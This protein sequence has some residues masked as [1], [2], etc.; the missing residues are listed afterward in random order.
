ME[1]EENINKKKRRNKELEKKKKKKKEEIK[2]NILDSKYDLMWKNRIKN[3]KFQNIDAVVSVWDWAWEYSTSNKLWG[4]AA[5]HYVTMS[6]KEMKNIE[7]DNILN[8]HAIVYMWT[9]PP[10]LQKA[11]IL[12]NS[13][14]LKF[15]NIN[16][17]WGKLDEDGKLSR[18]CLGFYVRQQEEYLMMFTKGNPD[19]SQ[20]DINKVN[21]IRTVRGEHSEKPKEII[22][23]ID[24]T[25][26]NVTKL[27][28]FSRSTINI[29]FQNFGNQ[30][31]LLVNTQFDKKSLLKV[32]NEQYELVLKKN[33]EENPNFFSKDKEI[34]IFSNSRQVS[35]FDCFEKIKVKKKKEKKEK[36]VIEKKEEIEK[37]KNLTKEI[38]N[39]PDKKYC[40]I[41]CN[42][43]NT[44]EEELRDFVIDDFKA[45]NCILLIWATPSN[46]EMI[47]DITKKWGFKF[48]TCFLNW[49]QTES[50]NDLFN[51]KIGYYSNQV[52]NYLLLFKQGKSLSFK[53]GNTWIPSVYTSIIN[54]DNLSIPFDIYKI[55]DNMF[56]NCPKIDL[57]PTKVYDKNWDIYTNDNNFD[58][59][60][61]DDKELLNIRK[62]QDV[63]KEKIDN[64]KVKIYKMID[65]LHKYGLEYNNQNN[66]DKYF[67]KI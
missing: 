10:F 16:T 14:G 23:I 3:E 13:M 44:S 17:T 35:I 58:F 54:N 63:K 12:G 6:S 66:I 67:N 2:I 15:I 46:L 57:F 45:K 18:R 43:F 8:K 7:F 60:A 55:F 27:E 36:K 29:N 25:F 11:I 48:T 38:I 52:E 24:K 19:I 1:E 51:N 26:I 32:R 34:K 59:P 64:C 53:K 62:K 40:I 22:E 28:M 61:Y 30:S 9:T 47:F 39:N 50:N 33:E 56:V 31:G 65:N 42:T 49:L 5:K 21:I 37:R 4:V 41:H 20:I